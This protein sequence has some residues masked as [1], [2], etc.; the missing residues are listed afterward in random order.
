MFWLIVTIIVCTCVIVWV[1]KEQSPEGQ[2]N[3]ILKK[4]NSA[5][6][7]VKPFRDMVMA[8]GVGTQTEESIDR[9]KADVVKMENNYN[10]LKEK[11]TNLKKVLEYRTDLNNYILA[12]N[13]LRNA[14][15]AFGCDFGPDSMDNYG[16]KV[17]K[18][19]PVKKALE[20]KFNRLL[21][22]Q[23]SICQI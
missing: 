10:L 15:E 19:E 13:S 2:N 4:I 8:K 14:W 5:E 23:K 17:N 3:K 20:E 16:N 21:G 12:L 9:F 6:E 1:V 11:E 18:H 22:Y 7:W